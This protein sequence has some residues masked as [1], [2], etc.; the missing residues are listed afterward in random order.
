VR[1]IFRRGGIDTPELDARLL[2][3]LAFGVERLELVNREREIAAPEAL[4]RLQAVAARRLRG[5]PVFRIIGEKG[6]WGLSF[7]LNEATLVPRPETEM[8][9]RRGLELL[10][11]RR[12][13]RILDL[14]TGT[15]CIVIALL[16]ELP[17]ATAVAVDLAGAA[18]TAARQNAE[19]HGVADRLEL[20]QGSW[21]APL[22]AEERFDLIVSNPPYIGQ[23]ELATL[24]PEVR[25]HDPALALDGGPDGLAAYREIVATAAAFLRP[26]GILLLEIGYQQ[27]PAVRR[28]VQVAGFERV[29]LEKDMA[30]LDR[31]VVGHHL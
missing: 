18:V 24:A 6:F 30:G 1:D 10:E 7:T 27:G 22:A 5:E 15:G 12:G 16:S 19:R 14:G 23:D 13:K 2:A 31:M 17:T 3:E 11:V 8:L 21:F 29:T 28:L 25:E 4:E 20:R 26:G 9:V